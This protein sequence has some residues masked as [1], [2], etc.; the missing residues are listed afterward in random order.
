MALNPLR[1]A[2]IVKNTPASFERDRRNMGMW[3]YPVDEFTW[4]FFALGKAFRLGL[5]FADQGAGITGGKAHGECVRRVGLDQDM[6]R[7]DQHG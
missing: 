1:V 4:D 3:S 6:R 7:F 5:Q 2:V